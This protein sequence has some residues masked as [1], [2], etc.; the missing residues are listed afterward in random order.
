MVPLLGVTIPAATPL[1]QLLQLLSVVLVAIGGGMIA[2]GLG[3]LKSRR[4]PRPPPSRPRLALGAVMLAG[5]IFI[6]SSPF[7]PAPAPDVISP[8]QFSSSRLPA[9]SVSAPPGW[10][11]EHDP[12]A[13]RLV[14]TGPR[15]RLVIETARL[16]DIEDAAGLLEAFSRQQRQDGLQPTGRS[17]RT[18]D[19]LNAVG[20][21]AS[22]NAGSVVTWALHRV[23][24]LFTVILCASDTGPDALSACDPVLS[25]LTW[26]PPGPL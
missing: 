18:F 13:G 15:A 11:F 17:P 22:G 16:A 4:R 12:E 10:R 3:L 5:A 1:Q 14:A 20:M 6:W 19:G 23:E 2:S 8:S 21:L 7:R 24:R 9:A 25:T 26:R